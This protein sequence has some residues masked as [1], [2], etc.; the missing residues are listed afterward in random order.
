MEFKGKLIHKSEVTKGK[1]KET[2]KDWQSVEFV[3]EEVGQTYPQKANFKYFAMDDKCKWV[4]IFANTSNI[5]DIIE[6]K[7]SIDAREYNGKFYTELKA[8]SVFNTSRKEGKEEKPISQEPMQ[9]D[10]NLGLPF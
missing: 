10:E 9:D 6:V 2:N 7:F 5:G 8:Y 4:G 3:L 1:T